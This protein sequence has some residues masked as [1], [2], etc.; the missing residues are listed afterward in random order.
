MRESC[1]AASSG[2]PT[3]AGD[4]R[5]APGRS[6]RAPSPPSPSSTAGPII[7]C[8]VSGGIQA[9]W[10][11]WVRLNRTNGSAPRTAAAAATAQRARSGRPALV[12]SRVARCAGR[13]SRDSQFS[14][15]HT[16]TVPP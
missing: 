4:S 3:A 8:Q 14:S 15:A 9:T 10:W 5:P 11:D 2:S 1:G 7:M 13:M 12:Q 16:R 6:S